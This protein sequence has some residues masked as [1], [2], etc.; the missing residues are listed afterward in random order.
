MNNE[1][2]NWRKQIDAL[3]EELLNVIAK[4][5][6]IVREIGLYKREYSIKPLDENR[7]QALLRARLL[8]AEACGLSKHFIQKLFEIIHT[9]ALKIEMIEE[10]D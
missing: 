1:L 7:W 8:R 3:D 5:M 6:D 10:Y 2:E 9:Y 4:R